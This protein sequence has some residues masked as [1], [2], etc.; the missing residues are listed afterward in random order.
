MTK[1]L[2]A[3]LRQEIPDRSPF[4]FMRQA[5]RYLP[6]Y[7]ALRAQASDFVALC[8]TPKLAVE[9]T[10]QPLRRFGMDA[11]ILFSDILMVPYGLGVPL[12]FEEGRGPL[13]K[14]VREAKDIPAFDAVSFHARVAPI[15]DTVAGVRAV[16]P[17]DAALIGF[18]GSPWTVASYMVEGGS[19][20]DFQAVKAWAYHDPE[21]FSRLIGVLAEATVE[22]LS[23]QVEAGAEVLQLFDSWAGVLDETLFARWVVAPT[24][25]IVSALKSR[26]PH[27]PIIGFARR[28]GTMTES[29]LRETGVN[30]VGLDETVPL[31]AARALPGVIQGNLDNVL[32]LADR[33]AMLARTEEILTAWQG[34][35][36]VFNLGHGI[37]PTTPVEHVAALAERLRAA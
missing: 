15:Y 36:F 24:R 16:L 7:R 29:Y 33:A 11:A 35:P 26:Y 1:R 3:T 25:A 18:A 19:S 17:K 32:L 21:G 10:L 30:A 23:R 5:G 37:L 34:R 22:Y 6:E 14:A 8:L 9:I 12:R 13:L 31:A 20:K 27:V 28:A 2:L 4:W